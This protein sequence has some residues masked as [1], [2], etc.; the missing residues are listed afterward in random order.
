MDGDGRVELILGGNQHRAKPQT[1]MYAS[2]Y[3][4]V[5]RSTEDRQLTI[6]PPARTGLHVTGQVRDIQRIVIEG[7]DH[8]LVARNDDT[9]Q[10]YAI[11]GGYE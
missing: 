1:G 8:L 3:G 9:T 2:S 11:G 4:T 6:V 10:L 7:Q 5:I